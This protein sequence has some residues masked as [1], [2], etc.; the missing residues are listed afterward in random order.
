MH[1]DLTREERRQRT[2][3]PQVQKQQGQQQQQLVQEEQ[4]ADSDS[5]SNSPDPLSQL[6]EVA[7][8]AAE[9]EARQAKTKAAAAGA[10]AAAAATQAALAA[11]T[12]PSQPLHPLQPA[13]E[14]Q[15]SMDASA[16]RFTASSPTSAS[17]LAAQSPSSCRRAVHTAA[18]ATQPG[19]V[20]HLQQLARQQPEVTCPRLQQH[21]DQEA[22]EREVLALLK[23][24]LLACISL[25]GMQ[26]GAQTVAHQAGMAAARAVGH[27]P[28]PAQALQPPRQYVSQEAAA[29]MEGHRQ[30]DGCSSSGSLEQSRLVWQDARQVPP[31]QQQ[32]QQQQQQAVRE[33][34]RAE[35]MPSMSDVEVSAALEQMEWH[36]HEFKSLRRKVLAAR[37]GSRLTASNMNDTPRSAAPR[38]AQGAWPESHQARQQQHQAPAPAAQPARELRAPPAN[39][40]SVRRMLAYTEPE[41]ARRPSPQAGQ[42]WGQSMALDEAVAA[43][44]REVYSM[45]GHPQHYPHAKEVHPAA[46]MYARPVPYQYQYLGA[47]AGGAVARQAGLPRPAALP[48]GY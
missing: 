25:D 31:Q 21:P 11:R 13:V 34:A 12:L 3:Q 24:K 8:E 23:R 44:R 27:A 18:P 19:A 10:M 40:S 32:R 4:W 7:A 15:T 28:G 14:R 43:A 47:G 22:Q 35:A 26:R 1:H 41:M 46:A 37:P 29:H 17:H 16:E 38:P 48:A 30:Y 6:A 5:D 39:P 2:Q 33:A 45:P 20:A 42:V 9:V 36:L